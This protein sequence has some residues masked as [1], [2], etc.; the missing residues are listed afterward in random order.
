VPDYSRSLLLRGRIS[1][2]ATPVLRDKTIRRWLIMTTRMT[3]SVGWP[4]TP[5]LLDRAAAVLSGARLADY[6]HLCDRLL[7]AGLFRRSVNRNPLFRGL[8]EGG[9]ART[10]GPQALRF[11][12]TSPRSRR[13]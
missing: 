10:Q 9:T 11:I 2:M 7:S 13:R 12:P 5:G 4:P 3:L 1:N 6:R 8:K